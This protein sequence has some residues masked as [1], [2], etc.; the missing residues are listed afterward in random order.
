MKKLVYNREKL[1]SLNNLIEI[2]IELSNKF[3]KLA[4]KIYYKNTNSEI[5]LYYRY[6]NYCINQILTNT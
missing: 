5:K 2:V 4:I 1:N 3:Y 6:I